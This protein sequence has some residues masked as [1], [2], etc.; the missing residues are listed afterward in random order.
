MTKTAEQKYF[1]NFFNEKEIGYTM[2]EI[3]HQ[4]QMHFLD[5]DFVIELI[6]GAPKAEQ[7]QIRN[8]LVKIDFANGDVKHFLK[9]LAESYIKMQY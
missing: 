1:E 8:T 4:G 3:E 9:F 7:M 5:T 6:K 2:F